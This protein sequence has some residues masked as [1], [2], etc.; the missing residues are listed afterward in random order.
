MANN[1]AFDINM[2]DMKHRTFNPH[3]LGDR[4]FFNTNTRQ[5]KSWQK[6]NTK[7]Q[8]Q[9]LLATDVNV[10]RMMFNESSYQTHIHHNKNQEITNRNFAD[11]QYANSIRNKTTYFSKNNG[12]R[13]ASNGTRTVQSQKS[14]SN[15]T[16]MNARNFASNNGRRLASGDRLEPIDVDNTYKNIAKD[17][18]N[19]YA[20]FNPNI[21]Y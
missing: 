8:Q 2:G 4:N 18:R 7:P 3:L 1:R 14:K 9:E 21:K 19:M 17:R 6:Y 12:A 11:Y 15:N 20:K 10:D 5:D 13:I 16:S